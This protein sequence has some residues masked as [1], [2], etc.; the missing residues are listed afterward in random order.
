MGAFLHRYPTVVLSTDF[1]PF[2]QHLN[3]DKQDNR[4]DT[5]SL[6][7]KRFLSSANVSKLP[8]LEN[9]TSLAPPSTATGGGDLDG[10]LV[11]AQLVVSNP[12][13]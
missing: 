13:V 5:M 1:H 9:T 7:P 6:R 4:N 11:V 10:Q 3:H 8:L 2:S 12:T